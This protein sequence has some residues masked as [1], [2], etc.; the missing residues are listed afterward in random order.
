MPTDGRDITGW[1]YSRDH[2]HG[3]SAYGEHLGIGGKSGNT[4]K[5]IFQSQTLLAGKTEI[6]RW[7]WQHVALVRDGEKV[8]IY[9][10]GT[11]E[12]EAEA[13]PARPTS[14]FFGTRSDHDSSWEGRLDEIAIFPSALAPAQIKSLSLTK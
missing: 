12:I 6:P 13:P 9:L 7:T 8:R 2:S 1:F 11:L 5:L 14:T 3:I 10:N 4:G